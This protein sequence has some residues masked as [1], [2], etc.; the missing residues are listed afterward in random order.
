MSGVKSLVCAAM[1]FGC[2]SASAFEL[3]LFAQ[4][5]RDQGYNLPKPFGLSVGAMHVEQGVMIDSIGFSGLSFLGRPLK[6]DAIDISAAPGM[7]RSEVYTLRADAWLLPF[8]NVYAIGG[9]MTGES[10]TRVTVNKVHLPPLPPIK[11]NTSFDFDLDLDGYLY[12]G[13][14]VIAGGIGNWFTLI[15]ASLT[16]TE[17]TVID[18]EIDAFVL[19]P[20]VGYD[21]ADMGLPLRVW[22]GGMYQD[23]EQNLAGY[24]H[25][26]HFGNGMD[27]L[28]GIVDPNGDGRFAVEQ[29]LKT[30]WNTLVG[31]QYQFARDWSLLGEAGLGERKSAMLSLEYRF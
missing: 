27:E 22:V 20:R 19:S 21:F 3:P 17:L 10:S 24:I 28:I 4:E 6:P 2:G 13:G 16:K 30:P 5:A 23:V 1:I 29:H 11:P 31:F 14:V 15:D 18:G 8:L 26:L 9:K 7:Q 25:N 12:G